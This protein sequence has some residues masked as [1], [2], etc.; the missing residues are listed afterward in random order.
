VRRAREGGYALAAL[1]AAVTIMLIGLG[2][3]A[4]AWKYVMKNEREEELLFR[5]GQIADAIARY[6]KRN[7]NALPPSLDVLV[8][9]KYLRKPWQDPMSKGGKWRFIRQG[10][11]LTPVPTQQPR[12]VSQTTLAVRAEPNGPVTPLGG[13]V[14][15]ASTSPDQ[16]LR[17]F[18]GRTRYNE[19]IF[20]AGQPRV[21]GKQP[22]VPG[23]RPGGQ[24]GTS[25]PPAPGPPRPPQPDDG[26]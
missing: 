15:V 12:A 24:P 25:L 13:F 14:G 3:A 10:E 6:Q 9:G 11:S 7:A 1:L 8:K 22:V 21:V 17:L 19:W 2:A 23:P 16:S 20:A 18:N 4:P 5:G 26:T